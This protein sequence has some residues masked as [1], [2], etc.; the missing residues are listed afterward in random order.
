MATPLMSNPGGI[1]LHQ[2]LAEKEAEV[3]I[4]KQ[5]LAKVEET[6]SMYKELTPLL[7]E[8]IRDLNTRLQGS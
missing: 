1:P 6:L 8:K 3:R 5:S 2:A 7:R 4:L